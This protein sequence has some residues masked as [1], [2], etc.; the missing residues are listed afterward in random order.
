MIGTA[1]AA[2]LMWPWGWYMEIILWDKHGHE[3]RPMYV[4][5][6]SYEGCVA[7]AHVTFPRYDTSDHKR[8]KLTC[9]WGEQNKAGD[10]KTIYDKRR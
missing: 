7:D 5:E 1:L 4:E 9:C 10:C 2:S 8:I 6:Q 3:E